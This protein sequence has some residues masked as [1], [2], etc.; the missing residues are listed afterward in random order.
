LIISPGINTNTTTSIAKSR[1][2]N[3]GKKDYD[4][5]KGSVKTTNNTKRNRERIVAGA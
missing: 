5:E 4:E 2:V 3:P 1:R